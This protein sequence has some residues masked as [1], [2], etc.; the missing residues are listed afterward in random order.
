M[1]VI[2]GKKGKNAYTQIKTIQNDIQ[3]EHQANNKKPDIGEQTMNF[4]VHI[5]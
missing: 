2:P 3:K 4:I 1:F 5:R